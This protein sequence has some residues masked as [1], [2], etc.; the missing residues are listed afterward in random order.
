MLG[1]VRKTT[2]Y[3]ELPATGAGACP[4]LFAAKVFNGSAELGMKPSCKHFRHH[5]SKSFVA[6]AACGGDCGVACG[7]GLGAPDVFAVAFEDGEAAGL[8]DGV[9][10]AR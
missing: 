5:D 6:A 10:A 4:L 9:A 7:L 2:S 8:G 3:P 1:S